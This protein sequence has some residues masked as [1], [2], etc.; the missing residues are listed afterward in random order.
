MPLIRH[1]LGL[2]CS[3]REIL[4]VQKYI[5]IIFSKMVFMCKKIKYHRLRYLEM[6]TII[7][8]QYN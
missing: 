8:Y 4:S 6:K 7:R 2:I 1:C 5:V 3:R